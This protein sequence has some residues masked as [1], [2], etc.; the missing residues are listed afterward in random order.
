MALA[1]PR[2]A[3]ART[4]SSASVSKPPYCAGTPTVP[5]MAIFGKL[6]TGAARGWAGLGADPMPGRA[7]GQSGRSG[8]EGH[9]WTQDREGPETTKGRPKATLS[10]SPVKEISGAGD[11]IRTHDP[12][13]GKVMLY[14]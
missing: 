9:K 1:M 3:A 7:V 4:N 10:V 13:L 14:P 8:C 2:M 5:M 11:E 12:Y 6:V